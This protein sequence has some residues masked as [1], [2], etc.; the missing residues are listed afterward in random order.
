VGE[1]PTTGVRQTRIGE[2]RS[3]CWEVLTYTS[4]YGLDQHLFEQIAQTEPRDTRGSTDNPEKTY[5]DAPGS[6]LNIEIDV[7]IA[8]VRCLEFN[9]QA[10]IGYSYSA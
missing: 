10:V 1:K 5:Q 7:R 9:E 2:S 8:P 3:V 6:A 4:W